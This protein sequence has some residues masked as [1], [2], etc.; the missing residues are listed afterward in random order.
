MRKKEQENK[1]II[2]V[3]EEVKIGDYVLE[4]GDK[5]EVLNEE[6]DV[7]ERIYLALTQSNSESEAGEKIARMLAPIVDNEASDLGF[8]SGKVIR[9]LG[10]TLSGM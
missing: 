9:S 3:K 4:E 7:Q 2:E 8:N 10:N 5:V 1:N 6:T